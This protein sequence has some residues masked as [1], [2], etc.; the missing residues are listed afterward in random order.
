MAELQ[1]TDDEALAYSG[2][3]DADAGLTYP[4]VGDSSWAADLY[5]LVRRLATLAV[6]DLHVYPVSGNADAVGVRA[7]RC[8]IGA[9]EYSYAGA[10]PAVDGLA[11]NET[12]YLWAE[13]DGGGGVQVAS[14]AQG[15]GWPGTA[16][17]KLAEVTMASGVITSIVDR[18]IK[19]AA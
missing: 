14:A 15:V 9:T 8:R 3:T 10:D 18:R 16:H 2:T 13:D 12:T 5:R 19:L 6:F 11:D 4:T 7:G 17:L 1:L